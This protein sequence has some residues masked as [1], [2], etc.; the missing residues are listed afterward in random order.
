MTPVDVYILGDV[1]FRGKVVAREYF[2]GC[3]WF[4]KMP[5][6]GDF[7]VLNKETEVINKTEGHSDWCGRYRIHNVDTHCFSGFSDPTISV[8]VFQVTEDAT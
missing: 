6:K 2:V 3:H 8:R 1:T 7:I 5:V 4:E